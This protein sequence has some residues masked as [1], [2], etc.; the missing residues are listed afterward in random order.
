VQSPKIASPPP[1]P[2]HDLAKVPPLSPEDAMVRRAVTLA[3]WLD[4]RW[5]DPV[6]GLFAP[7]VGDMVTAAVG[8]YIVAAGIKKGLPAVVISRM[9]LNLAV[10]LLIGLVPALGDLLD[11]AYRANNRNARLLEER[12]PGK[13][14]PRDWLIVAGSALLFFA[15]L[16][17]PIVALIW[18]LRKLF[19]AG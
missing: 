18:L 5:L 2:T 8:L 6:I 11:F 7:E 16:A 17:I 10:D 13:S 12:A 14:T 4:D 1:E 19:G 15:V 9:L 3:R